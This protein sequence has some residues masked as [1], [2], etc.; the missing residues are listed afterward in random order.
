MAVE[1]AGVVVVF[2]RSFT[3]LAPD[4]ARLG[5]VL[6]HHVHD[7]RGEKKHPVFKLDLFSGCFVFSLVGFTPSLV[8]IDSDVHALDRRSVGP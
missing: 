1:R 4:V 2:G 3:G 8:R 5:C 6:V 7:R